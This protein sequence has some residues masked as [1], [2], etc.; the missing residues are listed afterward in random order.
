[1]STAQSRHPIETPIA[2]VDAMA[3]EWPII[4]ALLGGTPAMRAA[5][6]LFLPRRTLEDPKDYEARLSTSTLFPAFEEGHAE[7]IAQ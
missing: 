1:M 2:E 6:E 5:G 7:E 3:K 4:D